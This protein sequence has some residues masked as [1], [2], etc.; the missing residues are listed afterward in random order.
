VVDTLLG[1]AYAVAVWLLVP[2]AAALAR[3][4]VPLRAGRAASSGAP[5]AG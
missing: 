3:R 4:A 2:R 1:A 5:T